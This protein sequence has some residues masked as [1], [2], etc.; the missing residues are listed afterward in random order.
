MHLSTQT[1]HARHELRWQTVRWALLHCHVTF[2]RPT[3]TQHGV[4]NKAGYEVYTDPDY[5]TPFNMAMKAHVYADLWYIARK[6]ELFRDSLHADI[7]NSERDYNDVLSRRVET[8]DN[9]FMWQLV[10]KAVELGWLGSAGSGAQLEAVGAAS[11]VMNHERTQQ[12]LQVLE[13]RI[14]ARQLEQ[15]LEEATVAAAGGDW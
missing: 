7:V 8:W 4:P 11:G 12:R 6:A 13:D 2:E 15:A 3:L 10:S 5:D 1:D 14:S 9:N